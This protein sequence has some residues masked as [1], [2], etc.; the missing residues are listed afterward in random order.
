MR[1]LLCLVGLL[2][3][4]AGFTQQR[5]KSLSLALTNN[6]S[7]YPFSKLGALVTGTYHPGF[8]AG[9]SFNWKTAPKHDWYQSFKAGYFYHR[10]VQHAIPLYTQAG[11]RYKLGKKFSVHTALGAGYLHSIAATAV[12]K[13][14]E[15]GNYRSARGIGRP[16]ALVNITLGGAH[17]FTWNKKPLS[18]FVQYQQ[19]VQTPFN[20]SYVPL[21]PYNA[22]G[23]GLSSPLKKQPL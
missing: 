1:L 12:M 6:Q 16:Q 3:S 8:E 2:L 18:V 19:Q 14:D 11:Y 9:Y 23:I 10:F 22:F 15:D 20:A 13:A 5:E 4:C 17:H 7:A 21:L